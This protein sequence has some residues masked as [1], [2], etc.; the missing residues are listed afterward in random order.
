M[1]W[2]SGSGWGACHTGGTMSYSIEYRS[3]GMKLLAVQVADQ[4]VCIDNAKTC[5]SIKLIFAYNNFRCV[6]ILLYA[7]IY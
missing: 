2:G 4:L 7:N 5:H 1:G 6:I 3:K